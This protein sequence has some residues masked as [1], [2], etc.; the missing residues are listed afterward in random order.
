MAE[1]DTNYSIIVISQD[2]WKETGL[3]SGGFSCNYNVS[4]FFFFSKKGSN[5][6][7]REVQ[8]LRLL[9]TVLGEGVH[10]PSLIMK[11][12]SLMLCGQKITMPNTMDRG[13]WQATVLG[14]T[15]SRT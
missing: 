14:V 5:G 8:R 10:I 1:N 12:R 4:P 15:K 2:G 9:F 3:G 6:A 13:A 7:S 11:L